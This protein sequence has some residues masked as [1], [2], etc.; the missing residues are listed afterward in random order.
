MAHQIKG[1]VY[2]SVTYYNGVHNLTRAASV[3]F[4][5]ARSV[6]TAVIMQLQVYDVAHITYYLTASGARA[7][8]ITQASVVVL[9]TL[10][11]MR[12]LFSLINL[13]NNASKRVNAVA[14]IELHGS[15]TIDLPI[16]DEYKTICTRTL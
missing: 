4:H 7:E 3:V 8:T 14:I 15:S 16:R 10:N 2:T 5:F 11:I 13:L 1:K 12:S 6:Q 9:P